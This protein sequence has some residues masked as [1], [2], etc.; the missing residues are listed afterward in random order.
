MQRKLFFA[1]IPIALF[2]LYLFLSFHEVVLFNAGETLVVHHSAC[3]SK[4][5]YAPRQGVLT[6]TY[7][8]NSSITLFVAENASF[9]YTLGPQSSATFSFSLKK[10]GYTLFVCNEGK[11]TA[12][13]GVVD[14]IAF[15]YNSF[16]RGF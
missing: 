3:V 12:S 16:Y 15:R 8:A 7:Y 13:L 6:G 2:L 9:V 10:G 1:L 14:P 11:S 5:F 4:K